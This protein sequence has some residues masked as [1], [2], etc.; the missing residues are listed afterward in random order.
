[1]CIYYRFILDLL[2]I[3]IICLDGLLISEHNQS[4]DFYRVSLS[5]YNKDGTALIKTGTSEWQQWYALGNI[6][7]PQNQHDGANK[8]EN[9]KS[10]N[11]LVQLLNTPL[12]RIVQIKHNDDEDGDDA[13]RGPEERIGGLATEGVNLGTRCI[14]ELQTRKS[15][16]NGENTDQKNV[17]NTM[18]WSI[19]SLISSSLSSTTSTPL[20]AS[21]AP[22]NTT[23]NFQPLKSTFFTAKNDQVIENMNINIL[24]NGL[25]RV[26]L[27]QNPVNI[28]G[29]PYEKNDN[30]FMGWV[31]LRVLDVDN[32]NQATNWN[33]SRGL[34]GVPEIMAKYVDPLKTLFPL[35]RTMNRKIQTHIESNLI[36]QSLGDHT[37]I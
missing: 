8:T 24:N 25:W 18:G 28:L 35:K 22:P 7:A 31:L 17:V 5:V 9:K 29:D 6:A 36:D 20:I 2:F 26:T 13:S 30:P 10:D 16:K 1:M 12:Q 32:V 14:V 19:L 21:L 34:S 15:D 23:T 3:P 11:S 4:D 27:K 37:Y 33:P